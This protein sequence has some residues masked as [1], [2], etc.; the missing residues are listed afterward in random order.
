[1]T[2]STGFQPMRMQGDGRPTAGGRV[3]RVGCHQS[4]G[5]AAR[6]V[7]TPRCS[8]ERARA[9]RIERAKASGRC[10]R[11]HPARADSAAS[12][13]R[14]RGPRFRY[15]PV[16]AKKPPRMKKPAAEPTPPPAA[17]RPTASPAPPAAAGGHSAL[18]DTR[19]IRE[20]EGRSGSLLER[21]LLAS[22]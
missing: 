13:S 11:S 20:D 6:L 10:P 18:L 4:A 12:I 5:S 14:P 22:R 2:G 8:D 15:I 9:N 17:T 7:R 16:M 3:P 21:T 19:V 1:M